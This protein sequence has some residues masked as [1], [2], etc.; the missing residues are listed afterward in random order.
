MNS[1]YNSMRAYGH[2]ENK[3]YNFSNRKRAEDY[4]LNSAKNNSR[5][6]LIVRILLVLNG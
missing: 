6:P 5:K 1:I 2:R 4:V 3:G